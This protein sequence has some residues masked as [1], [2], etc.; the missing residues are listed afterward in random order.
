LFI[1]KDRRCSWHFHELKDEVFFV[2]RGA[3]EVYHSN[4]DL[5]E[6]A[7]MTLLGPGEKFH[8]PRGMRHQMVALAD[9]ELFE[10]STQHFDSDSHRLIKGD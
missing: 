5:L 1:A 7:D 6:S 2:Y 8:V 4:D 9:T 10:F 3:I